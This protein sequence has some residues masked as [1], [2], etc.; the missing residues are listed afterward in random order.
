M[1]LLLKCVYFESW[2]MW[3][4][5]ASI[6]K[7]TTILNR[8]V[9]EI[10]A[11]TDFGKLRV[12]TNFWELKV[13]VS[14]TELRFITLILWHVIFADYFLKDPIKRNRLR[15]IRKNSQNI[16]I[17]GSRGMERKWYWVWLGVRYENRYGGAKTVK[18]MS[19]NNNYYNNHLDT[20]C[21][22]IW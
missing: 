16:V 18:R 9:F 17:L 5:L 12:I 7:L 2:R 6:F 21:T 10:I 11:S 15:P 20:P 19:N 13:S 8:G 4:F 22:H 1:V 14:F 3:W